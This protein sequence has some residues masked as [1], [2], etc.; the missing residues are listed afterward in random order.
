M[1]DHRCL[2]QTLGGPLLACLAMSAARPRTGERLLH[3]TS[4]L[5]AGSR[6]I[7]KQLQR[8]HRTS[9]L[10]D[11]HATTCCACATCQRCARTHWRLAGSLTCVNSVN[12]HYTC[13]H[14]SR[15]YNILR[16]K[17]KLLIDICES[18]RKTNNALRHN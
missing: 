1:G 17:N 11:Q 10:L 6:E 8:S 14:V 2:P 3:P 12:P 13:V 7:T 4:C 9:A 5:G 15:A 18:E 16:N